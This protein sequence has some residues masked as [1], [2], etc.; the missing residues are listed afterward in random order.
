MSQLRVHTL[1]AADPGDLELELNNLRD[2]HA[3]AAVVGVSHSIDP[4]SSR[5]TL[6]VVLEISEEQAAPAET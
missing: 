1:T 3:P 5:W 4:E 6:L 2:L